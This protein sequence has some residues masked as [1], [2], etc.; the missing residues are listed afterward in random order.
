MHRRLTVKDDQ[1]VIN[2][3]A[4]GRINMGQLLFVDQVIDALKEMAGNDDSPK[5][6][7]GAKLALEMIK[8]RIDGSEIQ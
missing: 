8:E 6:Q 7:S 5:A 2:K 3:P 4:A 1:M